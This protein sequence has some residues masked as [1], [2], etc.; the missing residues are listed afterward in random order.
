MLRIT[1]YRTDEKETKSVDFSL[2][3]NMK[4][5]LPSIGVR[6]QAIIVLKESCMKALYSLTPSA[7]MIHAVALIGAELNMRR[8][9]RTKMRL[10]PYT[11]Q[12]VESDTNLI[13]GH[14][15]N[16][17]NRQLSAVRSTYLF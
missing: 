14:S 13:V 15:S 9:F 6:F 8:I 11:K 12:V 16:L 3:M 10:P 7:L 5:D 17:I 4:I 1:C 2:L